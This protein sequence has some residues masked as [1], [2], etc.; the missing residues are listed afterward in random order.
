MIFQ[1][2]F[3]IKLLVSKIVNFNRH[4]VII[5]SKMKQIIKQESINCLETS[6]KTTINNLCVWVYFTGTIITRRLS[7]I[8]KS[9]K[10]YVC[11]MT[12]RKKMNVMNTSLIFLLT[13]FFLKCG[14]NEKAFIYLCIIFKLTTTCEKSIKMYQC[15]LK[16]WNT[17][18][19]ESV[20]Q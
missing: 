2:Y 10:K 17:S 11:L 3:I 6:P 14:T 5:N 18:W 20:T 9:I 1:W 8:I 4:P 16:H 19:I 13:S 7:L 15:S 12:S